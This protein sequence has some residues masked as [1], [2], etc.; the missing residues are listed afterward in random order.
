MLVVFNEDIRKG[1]GTLPFEI[2]DALTLFPPGVHNSTR[3]N[4]LAGTLPF[5]IPDALTLFFPDVHNSTRR[6]FLEF[7]QRPRKKFLFTLR[8]RFK[9]CASQS[10]ERTV[11][12]I[13]TRKEGGNYKEAP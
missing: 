2:P 7:T 12:S 8:W 11:Q 1:S 9:A 5:E 6:N 10:L 4:F 3:R 13:R